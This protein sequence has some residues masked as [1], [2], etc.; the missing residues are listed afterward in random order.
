MKLSLGTWAFSF[1]PYASQPW[2]LPKVLEFTARAG[3][4]GVE[5][6]GFRPHPH[7]DDYNSPERC[8]EL[9]RQIGSYGLGISGYAPD[10]SM[11]P[12]ALVD[13][14]AYMEQ[15][16]KS[17]R[18][19]VNC[20]IRTLRIDTA[21]PPDALA[22][23]EYEMRF[24]R[25]VHTWQTAAAAAWKDGVTVVW[26]FEPGF[27]LNKPSEV[28]RLV[29]TVGHPGFKVLFDPSHAYMGAVVGARHTGEKET[30]PGGVVE[31]AELLIDHIGHFHLIDSD[32]TLHDEETSAHAHFGQGHV[33]FKALLTAVKPVISKLPWWGVD[34]CFNVDVEQD[35]AEA[36]TYIRNLAK[37]VMP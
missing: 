18:F 28:K 23:Q 5:L 24:A 9:V 12:P 14:A 7:P 31:Y 3:Y 27:W 36:V 11:A 2:E 1:G 21:S 30:L 37:E 22:P 6:N 32:G 19:C 13:T 16:E 4:D 35:A 33:D 26:E 8:R 29:E 15:F 25:L 20:G 17:L 10:F 34:Y